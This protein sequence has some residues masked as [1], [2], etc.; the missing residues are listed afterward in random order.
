MKF[1]SEFTS[2]P[3]AGIGRQSALRWPQAADREAWAL[4]V[5]V[6]NSRFFRDGSSDYRNSPLC[7]GG[8]LGGRSGKQL[9]NSRPP[10]LLTGDKA[11]QFGARRWIRK[12]R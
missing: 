6:I 3:R 5:R 10:C 4:L 2:G 8:A 7:L 11:C 1:Y 12:P 9:A